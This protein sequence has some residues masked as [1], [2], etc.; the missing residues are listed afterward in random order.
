MSIGL[1][2]TPHPH[3]LYV[4]GVRGLFAD[5]AFVAVEICGTVDF[6]GALTAPPAE[7]QRDME[8]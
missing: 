2:G 3:V 7:L 6:D 8:I 5:N 4:V 1:K